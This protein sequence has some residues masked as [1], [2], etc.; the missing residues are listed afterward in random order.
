MK[1]GQLMTCART[2][3][4]RMSCFIRGLE[5][6]VSPLGAPILNE[7]DCP[8]LSLSHTIFTV[9]STSIKKAVSIVHNCT[10]T[11]QFI[12]MECPR[13]V[14]R[15]DVT[16]KRLEYKHDFFGNPMFCLNVYLYEN[17]VLII[18][19]RVFI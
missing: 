11:C 4:G 15:E 19:F 5:E 9:Y 18:T 12:D 3:D 6:M 17:R 1:Y 7:F 2:V 10:D 13:H 16:I 8:L 14:E